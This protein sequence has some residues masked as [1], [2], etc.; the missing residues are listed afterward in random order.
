MVAETMS[1]LPVHLV[2]GNR[3]GVRQL[4]RAGFSPGLFRLMVQ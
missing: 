1:G 3:L 2:G 4:N